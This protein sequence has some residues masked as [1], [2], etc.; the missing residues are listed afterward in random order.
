VRLGVVSDLHLTLDPAAEASW[1]NPFDFAGVPGRID[2]ARALFD[3]AGVDA[4][5]ACGDLTHAGDEGSVRAVRERLTVGRE[6]PLLAVAG[7]H[8]C[9]ERDDQLARCGF[10]TRGVEVGG[11]R[12]AGVAIERDPAPGAFRWTGGD[13][14]GG[15]TV[16]ASH[17]PVLPCAARLTEAGFVHPGDLANRRELQ[18]HLAGDGPV[19]GLSGHI[20]ARDS[21]ADG[22]VLQLSAGA[23][24][25]SPYEVA[26]VDVDVARAE[27]RVRRR[28]HG[29]GPPARHD[30]VLAAAD[31][32][33]TFAWGA[34][35]CGS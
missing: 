30:P 27:V 23:L 2:R 12:V 25:E 11:V 10:A 31:E 4:V 19:V 1:H 3:G 13:A 8:D 21:H 34:W 15:A 29:L 26:I 14:A 7:N 32:T 9:L 20:H 24:V 16:V 6:R 35:R 33:W 18:A 17:F 28:V 22:P 5:M